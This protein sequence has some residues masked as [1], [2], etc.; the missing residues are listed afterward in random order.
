MTVE[1]MVDKTVVKRGEELTYTVFFN[2]TGP[3]ASID[4]YVNDTLDPGLVLV[5][6]SD[7]VNRTGTSWYY[8]AIAASSSRNI[9]F[10]VR[11]NSSA[12]AGTTINNTADLEF[13]DAEGESQGPITSNMVSTLVEEVDMPSVTVSKAA[14]ATIIQPGDT[15][16]YTITVTNGGPGI[17]DNVTVTDYVDT[18]LT[19][20]QTTGYVSGS[21]PTWDLGSLTPGESKD[22][23]ITASVDAFIDYD[24]TVTNNATIN[25]TTVLGDPLEGAVTNTVST[26]IKGGPAPV[27][28]VRKEV[29]QSKAEPGD[30]I[31]YTIYFNNTGNAPADNV[32]VTDALSS[33]LVFNSS[34]ADHL[35]SGDSW[36]FP[37]IAPSEGGVLVVN[38]TVAQGVEN[39]TL[40]PNNATIS[41]ENGTG[42]LMETLTTNTVSTTISIVLAP[43]IS[44]EMLVDKPLVSPGEE[45]TY[46]IYY[47]N[48]GTGPAARVTIIEVLPIAHVIFQNTSTHY[49]IPYQWNF[50][51]VAVGPHELFVKVL[52]K[53]DVVRDTRI[54]NVV[55]V[56]YTDMEDNHVED[57]QTSVESICLGGGGEDTKNP[58]VSGHLPLRGDYDIPIDTQ[59]EIHFSEAMNTISVEQAI[60]FDPSMD[61]NFTWVGNTLYF[62]PS[63]DLKYATSYTVTIGTGAK[64]LAGNPVLSPYPFTFKTEVKDYVPEDQGNLICYVTVA[65]VAGLMMGLFIFYIAYRRKFKDIEL[66]KEELEEEE[67]TKARSSSKTDETEGDDLDD[68]KPDGSMDE[69]SVEE[70]EEEAGAGPEESLVETEDEVDPGDDE[71]PEEAQVEEEPAKE[72]SKEEDADDSSNLDDIMRNLKG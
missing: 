36:T 51:N 71:L 59:I 8:P 22:L 26:L 18:A 1:K 72:G 23:V 7:D 62:K 15:M 46:I 19:V 16:E 35:R 42:A 17:A 33:D 44:L 31:S 11:V 64:D 2:N 27:L 56:N 25:W 3:V 29:D 48:T 13:S 61:G 68:T 6:S 12:M 47:N 9:T 67:E 41:Y 70:L 30:M 39:G 20:T 60:T 69:G 50:T 49:D 37:T 43:V 55:Q 4:V 57:L 28:Q 66:A 40:I 58:T 54:I 52:V 63:K 53:D 65:L 21:S 34:N 38:A 14:T 32:T 5:S 24:L 45:L 10:T